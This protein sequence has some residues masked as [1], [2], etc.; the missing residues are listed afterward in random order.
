MN[1]DTQEAKATEPAR[2]SAVAIRAFLR[3][4]DAWKVRD[5]DSRTLLGG[6]SRT[7]LHNWKKGQVP[8]LSRDVLE[9]VS[10]VL[11]IYKALQILLPKPESAD[12]WV[13][14]PN[15]FFNGRPALER[16]LGGNVA[17]LYEVRK[18][19]DFAR[20]NDL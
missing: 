13:R 5:D 3:I 11:G 8:T 6:I 15:Q 1:P 12:A 10:Y 9:R 2:R 14:K 17:D 20:G 7:T 16:M 4:M 19:L 18:Y